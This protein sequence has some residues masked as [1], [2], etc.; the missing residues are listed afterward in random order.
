MVATGVTQPRKRSTAQEL[1]P[2]LPLSRRTTFHSAN[3]A[4]GA[5]EQTVANIGH[6]VYVMVSMDRALLTKTSRP[7]CQNM[8]DSPVDI[9]ANV[10]VS[11][12]PALLI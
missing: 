10:I 11:E 7:K 12:E 8:S 6:A 3:E 5:N 9:S 1:N 2:G 4:V